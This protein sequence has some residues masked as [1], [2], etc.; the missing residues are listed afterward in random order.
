M[1]VH[2]LIRY[3]MF[4]LIKAYTITYG[5]AK[6]FLTTKPKISESTVEISS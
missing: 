5:F 4:T 6:I 2:K 3:L 1:M